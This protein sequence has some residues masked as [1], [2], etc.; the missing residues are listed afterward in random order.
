MPNGDSELFEFRQTAPPEIPPNFPE[1]PKPPM[2][3]VPMVYVEAPERIEYRLMAREEL[4]A[5]S[6]EVELNRLGKEGW[7]LLQIF[8]QDKQVFWFLADD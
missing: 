2:V 4:E 1:P 6:L 7:W 3:S 5:K 8:R